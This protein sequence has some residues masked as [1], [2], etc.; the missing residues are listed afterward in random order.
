M[1]VLSAL[2][3]QKF[4]LHPL[5]LVSTSCFCVKY[6]ALPLHASFT[7]S[8]DRV[9]PLSIRPLYDPQR[10]A[11][12]VLMGISGLAG[13]FVM[14]VC[15]CTLLDCFP[16]ITSRYKTQ[17]HRS[18]FTGAEWLQ[19]VAVGVVNLLMFSWFGTI[20]VWQIHR[21]HARL[22]RWDDAM[23]LSTAIVHTAIHGIVID[24]WFFT[25]HW[26]LHRP[27]LY[28]AIH[29]FHHRFKA[30]TAVACTYANPVEFSIGNVMGVV[31]GPAVT[32]CHPFVA[33]FWMALSLIS[34]SMSH[35]GYLALGA[36]NHDQHH[37]HFDYNFGVDVIMDRLCG[38]RFEG[39]TRQ[40][41]VQAKKL[42][43]KAL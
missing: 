21:S 14:A 4:P 5:V 34:T 26:I 27:L 6:I 40:K 32:N 12:A 10:D 19:A 20:P 43:T 24:V 28:K 18:Y 11:T 29:K 3:L 42:N 36:S 37:E 22:A 39:S 7:A 31:L 8:L 38:T 1:A 25:T 2:L 23:D 15:F 35:S 30:P 13:Y 9:V 17:G 41:A 16:K 33:A